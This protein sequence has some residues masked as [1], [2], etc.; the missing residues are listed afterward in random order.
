VTSLLSRYQSSLLFAQFTHHRLP[1]PAT[2][3]DL[4]LN[5]LQLKT[6]KFSRRE[7]IFPRWFAKLNYPSLISLQVTASVGK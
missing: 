1:P 5:L 3:P 6:L 4:D 7:E 2:L